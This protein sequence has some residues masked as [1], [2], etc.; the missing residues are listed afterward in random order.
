MKFFIPFRYAVFKDKIKK[1]ISFGAAYKHNFNKISFRYRIKL[2]KTYLDD[3]IFNPL[4]RNKFTL[5]SKI[6]KKL[7]PYVSQEFSHFAQD[8]QFDYDEYRLSVGVRINLG[9]KR[10][11]KSF[12][13]KIEGLSKKTKIKPM[14]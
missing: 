13:Q 5:G 11:P 6:N 1:R 12:T 10:E 4:I 2:Q 7:R 3:K 9:K 14:Y 8:G